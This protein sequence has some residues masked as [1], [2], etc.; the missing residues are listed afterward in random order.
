MHEAQAAT[1]PV[2][3]PVFPTD[4]PAFAIAGVA[5]DGFADH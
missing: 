5:Q 4:A 3:H 2:Q 1:L